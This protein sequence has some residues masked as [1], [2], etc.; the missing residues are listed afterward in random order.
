[1]IE[2]TPAATE[3]IAAYF[4][5]KEVQPIRIFL[6]EGEIIYATGS[7]KRDRL[8][9]FLRSNG[10][11]SEEQLRE[12]L[13]QGRAQKKALGKILIEKG[14]LTP[15]KLQKFIH[16]QIEHLI[17]NLF[18]WDKGKFEY[19]DAAINL[20]GMIVAKINVTRLLLEA[21]R[22]IDEISI[23]KKHIPSDLLVYRI[24]CKISEKDEIP[25]DLLD[26][27]ILGLINGQRS[28]RRV[29]RD[30]GFDEYT[31]Y[32]ILYSLL[33]SG[34]IESAGPQ[35]QEAAPRYLKSN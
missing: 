20:K 14:I 10:I 9:Y 27:K 25:L 31:A 21:S 7:H 28:I 5:D 17:F 30:G 15:G 11:V 3:Q 2:V 13:K 18:L 4:S 1:M 19:N 34:L 24:T 26:L 35:H 32:K 16:L 12:S 29:I 23:L 8:G 6:N 33:T 22:R